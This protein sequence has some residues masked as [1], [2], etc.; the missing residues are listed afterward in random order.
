M[1]GA[2]EVKS[3]KILGSLEPQNGVWSIPYEFYPEDS[4]LL[5]TRGQFFLVVDFETSPN[6]DLQ[7]AA[8]IVIDEIK[9]KYYGDLEGTPLQ[10]LEKAV[11][12][13]KSKLLEISKNHS[14]SITN[15]NFNIVCAVVWGRVLYI[16][17]IGKT[18]SII[19]RQG[20]IVDISNKTSG[21]II[22][23]SG[24]LQADDVVIIGT[25]LFE[26]QFLEDSLTEKMAS[27]EE[28]ITKSP[29]APQLSI[30]VI[31]FK[32]TILP[33]KKDLLGF[34]GSFKGKKT[35]SKEPA[36]SVKE[37]SVEE[38][39]ITTLGLQVNT[40]QDLEASPKKD[41]KGAV[42][43]EMS[44][45][46][47]KD[48]SGPKKRGRKPKKLVIPVLLVFG[49]LSIFASFYFNLFKFSLPKFKKASQEQ[50][51]NIDVDQLQ[52]DLDA[53]LQNNP[54]KESLNE[55]KD[56]VVKANLPSKESASLL[57]KINQALEEQKDTSPKQMV[58]DFTAKN[59]SPKINSLSVL[60]DTSVFVS[61]SGSDQAYIVN[62][63]PD[64]VNIK[65]LALGEFYLM[66]KIINDTYYILL[67]DSLFVGDSP[68]NLK[69]FSLSKPLDNIA[70]FDVYFG[71][72]YVL[73][74]NNV[75][76]YVK[77]KDSYTQSVWTSLPEGDYKSLSVDGSIYIASSKG[78][79]KYFKGE[80]ED[81][82][83]ISEITNPLDVVTSRD[84]DNLYVLDSSNNVYIV[85]KEDAKVV[86][87]IPLK[88]NSSL[89]R[90]GVTEDTFYVSDITRLYKF[91]RS[92]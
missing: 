13:G 51:L 75:Y 6:V 60:E 74:D 68:S 17:Q 10:A 80:L 88:L 27:L 61:D 73:S 65:D 14:S 12:S 69:E 40:P 29:N 24:L 18:S 71:N 2:F 33:N 37:P 1:V 85:N 42:L 36:V 20:K 30:I 5:S 50:I 67:K 78:L 9:E 15:F 87:T 53:L 59:K 34:F 41:E 21:E 7:L 66:A 83:N 23:S 35:S 91:A 38:G 57:S 63:T 77:S 56:R 72:L 90:L 52:K 49:I 43:K 47:S 79:S 70:D 64:E 55:F 8:K 62:I 76:K 22:T 39:K 84:E 3:Q 16:A 89:R 4:D 19:I 26:N 44:L 11:Q 92:K 25:H 48:V 82:F 81:T 45:N 32:K 28:E 31:S 54:S 46:G 86:K 58:F